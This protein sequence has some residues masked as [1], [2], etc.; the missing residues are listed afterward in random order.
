M[1]VDL[2]QDKVM[3][4]LHVIDCITRTSGGPSRSVQGLVSALNNAGVDAWLLAM[5]PY[6][7][8]W[9]GNVV[10]KFKTTNKVHC[11]GMQQSVE[12]IIDELKPDI[13]HIHSIW[14]WQLHLAARAARKKGVPYILAPRGTIEPW[15]LRQKW[16]KKKLALMTYQGYDFKHAVAIHCTAES[17]AKQAEAL[18]P[19]KPVFISPN[20]VNVPAALPQRRLHEDGF[21]RAL[22]V[23]RFHYKKGLINLVDAW[24]KVRPLGWKMELVGTDSAGYLSVVKDHIQ[25]LG[26]QD[27]FIITG[28][29]MDEDKWTAY[30]RAD[31]FILPSFSENFGIVVAEALYAGVPVITTK[32]T[33]WGDLESRACG[34]WIDI[35]VDPLVRAIDRMTRLT[36]ATRHEMGMRGAELVRSKYT[37]G[38]IVPGLM[39][40]YSQF[41]SRRTTP[42]C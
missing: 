28:A 26:L 16:F 35:G 4:V 21:R 31:L 15:S 24:T 29:M 20:A 39:R 36:D 17:E 6:G 12:R 22:F 34:M 27:D 9:V 2:N 13:I 19:M 32:A 25:A 41:T 40:Q 23:S 38:A 42:D 5:K 14:Q 1:R 3:R 18:F 33:P 10:T 37:W 8:P 30:R 11:W 7:I